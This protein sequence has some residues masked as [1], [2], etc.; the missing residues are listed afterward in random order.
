MNG[1]HT[2]LLGAAVIALAAQAQAQEQ[3]QPAVVGPDEAGLADIIVTA[4]RTGQTK[5]QKT[6][7]AISVFSA[8]TLG[9]INAVNV[10]DLVTLT[11]NL[12]VSQVTAS[13]AIYI[14]GIGSNNIFGGSDPDVTVQS[15]GVYLARAFTQFSDFV[16]IERIEVLRGPQ[17][18]L[19]GRNAIGGTINIISRLPDDE[20]RG[21][22]QLTAGNYSLFQG[23]AYIS[24]PIVPGKLQASLSGNYIRHGGYIDNIVPGGHDIN[25]ANRGGVRGQLRFEPTDGIEMITRADYNKGSE[26]FESFDHLLTPLAIA[27][28]ASSLIGDYT[29]AAINAPQKSH[30]EIWGVSEE[31][32]VPLSDTLTLKSLTAFRRSQYKLYVDIDGTEVYAQEGEQEETSRQFSQEFNLNYNS[33]ALE[34]VVGLYYFHDHQSSLVGSYNPL[35]NVFVRT[36]PESRTRSYAA[37]AQGTYHLTP[38][39]GITAGIRYTG[40]RKSIDASFDRATLTTRVS[41]PGFPFVASAAR[42]YHAWTPKI[43]VDYKVTPGVMIYASATRGYKSG[44]TN[45]AAATP[46]ALTFEPETIWSYEGGIKSELLD[47]RLRINVSAFKYDYKDLQVQSLIGPGVVAIGNAATAKVKGIELETSAKP[48]PNLLLTANLSLLDAKYD[49]FTNASVPG[50]LVPFVRGNPRYNAVTNTFDATGNRLNAAPRSSFSGSAQYDVPLESGKL[51]VRGEYYRQGKVYYDPSNV[52]IFKQKAYGLV[53]GSLGYNSDGGGWG[54]QLVG[55][56]LTNTRYLIN[57]AANGQ[58]PA[59]FAAAPR[60]VAI[61][62]TTSW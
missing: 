28:L 7:L 39:L 35:I 51:F 20:F 30:T 43:G 48:V 8:D 29:K 19:Y 41:A 21:K 12:N 13:A 5:A 15:D 45:Y 4:T 38:E 18:T 6:P 44:G 33:D 36:T 53:N 40:D 37:F 59:G 9:A 22:A 47:R 17:G 10:K 16:D 34:G 25:T 23:Q 55:K 32:R 52:Q 42:K 60:T 54:V 24:G 1:L 62:L 26:W 46:A 58:V 31:I 50:A 61:Q 3:T 27:P 14:R 49:T 11:P 57:I 2:Y 56:N